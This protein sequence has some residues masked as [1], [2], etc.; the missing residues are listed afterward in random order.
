MFHV[1][2]LDISLWL[3]PYLQDLVSVFSK[4]HSLTHTETYSTAQQLKTMNFSKMLL[5]NDIQSGN[6]IY[7]S[8]FLGS[9][10]IVSQGF[11]HQ[12]QWKH[13]FS[14]PF[15]VKFDSS[16]HDFFKTLPFPK[17]KCFKSSC[18]FIQYVFFLLIQYISIAD[19]R[20]G[21]IM[22]SQQP[23]RPLCRVSD[24]NECVLIMRGTCCYWQL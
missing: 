5:L 3:T 23:Q 21:V 20:W 24:S 9:V 4:L 14:L 15:S 18:F 13:S 17:I 10:Y 2:T 11:L 6:I 7:C 22:A 16:Q 12:K 1:H 8:S 19:L